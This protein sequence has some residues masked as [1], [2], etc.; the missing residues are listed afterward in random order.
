LK[1]SVSSIDNFLGDHS[2]DEDLAREFYENGPNGTK[3]MSALLNLAHAQLEAGKLAEAEKSAR[4]VL[5]WLQGHEKLGPDSP[6]ALGCM[7]ILVPCIWKQGRHAE[8]ESWVDRCKQSIENLSRGQ[9]AKYYDEE[10]RELDSVVSGLKE[11]E[12]GKE[13]SGAATDV[14]KL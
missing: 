12:H 5:P 10:K 4:E 3:D 13:G 8:A 11:Q 2:G 1:G 7:R 9:F 14:S 6:Q